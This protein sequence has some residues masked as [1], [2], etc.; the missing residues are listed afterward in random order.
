MTTIVGELPLQPQQ[1]ASIHPIA[2]QPR[3]GQITPLPER[4]N[5]NGGKGNADLCHTQLRMGL[6]HLACYVMLQFSPLARHSS[7]A[8]HPLWKST[9]CSSPSCSPRAGS[10]SSAPTS[11]FQ[12]CAG[13]PHCRFGHWNGCELYHE[14]DRSACKSH[15]RRTLEMSLSWSYEHLHAAIAASADRAAI[16]QSHWCCSEQFVAAIEGYSHLL[17]HKNET[18]VVYSEQLK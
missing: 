3:I 15:S 17:G 5:E 9:K 4:R 16:Q 13:T 10:G 11:H 18:Q 2:L 8:H 7:Q 6:K 1:P 12:R 14:R